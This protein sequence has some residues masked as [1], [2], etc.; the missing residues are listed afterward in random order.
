MC[1]CRVCNGY[2]DA[3]VLPLDA[4]CTFSVAVFVDSVPDR[5]FGF[6]SRVKQA[7]RRAARRN[8]SLF[9]IIIILVDS[10]C[11]VGV[12]IC[13][14]AIRIGCAL[15]HDFLIKLN[16]PAQSPKKISGDFPHSAAEKEEIVTAGS[17]INLNVHKVE[18][19]FLF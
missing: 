18:H 7:K 13:T 3:R 10:H 19:L 16:S 12:Y 5:S 11:S 17:F 2:F 1:F 8:S 4:S 15:F 14:R 9:C 6:A